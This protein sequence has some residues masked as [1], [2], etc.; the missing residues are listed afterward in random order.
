MPECE[1]Y[2]ERISASLDDALT[3]EEA[4]RLEEHLRQCPECRALA[5]QLRAVEQDLGELPPVPEGFADRVMEGVAQQE[6]VIPFTDCTPTESETAAKHKRTPGWRKPMLRIG[7]LAA[8]C[9]LVIGVGR[10]VLGS[11]RCGSAATGAGNC[12][13]DTTDAAAPAEDAAPE[14]AE[15]QERLWYQGSEYRPTDTVLEELPEGAVR[16]GP[17]A[18]TEEPA[19]GLDGCD[20]YADPEQPDTVYVENPDG[21]Y[22]C[23]TKE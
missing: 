1:A 2:W 21:G 20:V 18:E 8:C 19:S 17:L 23:W 12:M 10:F 15:S 9:V 22:S 4:A 13:A 14:S 6:Q 7:V 3:P 11:M 5:E 16:M